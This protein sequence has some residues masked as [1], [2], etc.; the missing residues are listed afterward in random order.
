VSVPLARLKGISKRF[1]PVVA[2]RSADLEVRAG[3]VH[4]VLGENGAGKTTLLNVLAGL[5]RSDAG[6]VEIEGQQV[7]LRRP[8]DAWDA[9]I[10]MV[11]QHFAL[12][13]TLSVLEN[14]AL[15]LRSAAAGL[16][17]PYARVR[18]EAT[19]L[20]KRTG[21]TVPFDA[22]VEEL[23]VGDRQRVEILKTLLRRPRILVLD[24][25]TAVLTPAEV[26]SLFALLRELAGSGQ[27]VVL[28]AHRL[29]EIL[30]VA[31]RVT[32]LRRG[33]SVL[34]APRDEVSEPG[35]TRAMIGTD[36]VA[37][38]RADRPPLPR[39][40]R[41]S[42]VDPVAVLEDV[43]VRGPRGQKALDGVSL[44]IRCGEIVGIAGVEGNGQ[45]E[46]A[47]TLA[48]RVLP[49]RG[50]VRVPLGAGLI[51]QD[52]SREGLVGAFDLASNVALTMHRDPCYRRGP[53]L[54]WH[55]IRSRT[56]EL[57]RRFGIRSAGPEALASTLSGGNQQRVVVA[58]ELEAASDLLVAENPTRG[59][60]V[61]ATSFVRG[62]L[63][64]L[65]DRVDA[66]GIVLISTDLD[67]VLDLAH[68]VLVIV[69]GRLVEVPV[70]ERTREG[71]GARMLS[72]AHA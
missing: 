57:V 52:R 42:T 35:L 44:E 68:R 34:S 29:D 64:R 22:L 17:L 32:V 47:L 30:G 7:K 16:R 72:V 53:V 67:E 69:R 54:R 38:G 58:R 65:A 31:N 11:H 25:P 61:A 62:E 4:G 26:G 48:G 21:L 41:G 10:G 46:L 3:E 49:E 39:R 13:P 66:P 8:R 56:I 51:P 71:V 15:G 59:L 63:R 5:V 36:V 27:G 60:D 24:E 28:V 14:L 18:R 33:R 70:G 20:A 55:A 40:T 19:D 45:R 43:H 23:G 9:G 2:L 1:G 50:S 6:V 12:V 37:P